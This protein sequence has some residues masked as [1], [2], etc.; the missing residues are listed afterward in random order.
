MGNAVGF[1][2]LK[3]PSPEGVELRSTACSRKRNGPI[4]IVIVV[5]VVV[6]VVAVL[7]FI[8]LQAWTLN[9]FV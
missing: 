1:G 9:D 6:V 8:C 7:V 5:V 4:M 2:E 3:K